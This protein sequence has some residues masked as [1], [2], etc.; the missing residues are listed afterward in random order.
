MRTDD[1]GIEVMEAGRARCHGQLIRGLFTCI[2][3]ACAFVRT[4]AGAVALNSA[5]ANVDYQLVVLNAS[6]D[7]LPGI[8]ATL[9]A[10][11]IVSERV[12]FS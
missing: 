2:L 3:V 10:E 9:V 11:S 6:T 8:P 7:E 1:V 5:A 4:N 12:S